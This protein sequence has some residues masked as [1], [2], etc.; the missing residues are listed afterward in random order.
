M[1]AFPTKRMHTVALVKES[2]EVKMA[3]A[4]KFRDK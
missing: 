3:V 4:E 2:S 1:H